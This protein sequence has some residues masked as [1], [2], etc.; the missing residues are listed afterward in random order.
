MRE[1]DE[2][3]EREKCEREQ[4][5]ADQQRILNLKD[6]TKELADA[7][8]ALEPSLSAPRTS[9]ATSPEKTPR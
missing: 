1:R 7:C 9:C 8:F 3:T 6:E 5:G 2:F 4:I